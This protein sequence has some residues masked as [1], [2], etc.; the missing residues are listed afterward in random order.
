M[1]AIYCLPIG[2]LLTSFCVAQNTAELQQRADQAKGR[3]CV[4]VSMQAARQFLDDADHLFGT[5]DAKAAHGAIDSSVHY[6]TRSV[7]CSVQSHKAE[8]SDEIELRKLIRRMKDVEQTLDSEDR[9]HLT[10][11]MAALDEQRTRLLQAM[12]GAAAANGGGKKR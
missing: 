1:K 9:P 8:K 12:F 10:R 6:A 5:G 11:S 2:L 3:D 4:H 7:D